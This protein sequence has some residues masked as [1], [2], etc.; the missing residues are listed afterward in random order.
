MREKHQR[1][2]ER[3]KAQEPL[4]K[5]PSTEAPNANDQRSTQL[6]KTHSSGVRK[7]KKKLVRIRK[8]ATIRSVGITA[9]TTQIRSNSNICR[10]N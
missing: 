10:T 6:S 9:C 5:A 1:R 4:A 7:I 2:R 3:N 8:N